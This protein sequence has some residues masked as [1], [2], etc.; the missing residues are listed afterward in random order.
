MTETPEV[1]EN[2]TEVP[3]VAAPP[4]AD[5]LV[6]IMAAEVFDHA[7]AAEALAEAAQRLRELVAGVFGDPSNYPSKKAFLADFSEIRD[8]SLAAKRL[9]S[10]F[11]NNGILEQKDIM[12]DQIQPGNKPSVEKYDMEI[13]ILMTKRA[14][15]KAELGEELT[16]DEQALLD[17]AAEAAAKIPG[18]DVPELP[19]D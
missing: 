16:A 10:A 14:K 2:V 18:A 13:E 5:S 8:L 11:R 7:A 1:A 19:I 9:M 3:E 15:R 6:G 4:V 12:L 17:K